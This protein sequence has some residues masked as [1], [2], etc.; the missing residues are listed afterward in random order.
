MYK[1]EHVYVYQFEV[2]NH[3]TWHGTSTCKMEYSLC[4]NIDGHNHKENRS[5]LE[6]M[7]RV[8]YGY[9]PKGVKFLYE[10]IQR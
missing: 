6:H 10:R 7:L 8:V 4:T 2:K 1:H 5:T 9:M 3:P